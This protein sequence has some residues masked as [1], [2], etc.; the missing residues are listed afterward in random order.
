M[1]QSRPQQNPGAAKAQSP[2]V[3]MVRYRPGPNYRPEKSLLEQDLR[4]HGKYMSD[5]TVVGVIIAAGPTF[6]QAGGLVLISV[7]N[8]AEAQSFVR[9]DP[10]V[11]AGI[12]AGEITDWRPVF[13][14]KSIFR[15]EFRKDRDPKP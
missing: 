5:Q 3:Y 4:E 1:Q 11:A 7:E 13:D 10:A 6:D 15:Q 8:L 9:N 14:A 12:F 2:L